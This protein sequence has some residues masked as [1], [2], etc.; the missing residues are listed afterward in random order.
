[1]HHTIDRARVQLHAAELLRS[2]LNLK[3]YSAACTAMTLLHVLFTACSQMCSP[4]AA[5][6]SL[7][8][9]P[10][11]KAALTDFSQMNAVREH[12]FDTGA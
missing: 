5:C 8:T 6:W 9:A 1:M 2:C 12:E 3:D 4:S 10:I 11:R 7:A